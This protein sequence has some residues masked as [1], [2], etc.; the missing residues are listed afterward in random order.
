MVG[1]AMAHVIVENFPQFSHGSGVGMVGL[2]M[3]HP[4]PGRQRAH[5]DP[6]H[7]PEGRAPGT[8]GAQARRE[9][10]GPP[11]TLTAGGSQVQDI[12]GSGLRTGGNKFAGR[13]ILELPL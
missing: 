9:R 8:G 11:A 10:L 7:R 5:I 3:A 2:A 6:A 13:A 12:M 4:L 1:L